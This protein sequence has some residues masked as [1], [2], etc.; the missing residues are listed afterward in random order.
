MF[1][2]FCV[3]CV[4]GLLAYHNISL[5]TCLHQSPLQ[6]VMQKMRVFQITY[7]IRFHDG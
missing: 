3:L 7:S 4:L 1:V 6:V 2:F 5:A